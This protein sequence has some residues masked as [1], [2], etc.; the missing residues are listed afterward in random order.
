MV[1]IV[2]RTIKGNVSSQISASNRD[3]KAEEGDDQ[4]IELVAKDAGWRS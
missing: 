2:Y 4:L 1:F 3:T